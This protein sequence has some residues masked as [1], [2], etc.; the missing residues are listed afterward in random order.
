M[1]AWRQ[2]LRLV[3]R[4]LHYLGLLACFLGTLIPGYSPAQSARPDELTTLEVE[5][6]YKV[7]VE[8]NLVLVRVVVRDA[9]GQTVGNLRREDFR[10]FDNGKPQ[11][12]SSF[13]VVVPSSEGGLA[14]QAG[15]AQA[16]PEPAG[17]KDL[18][19]S[20]P[21]RYLGLYFDDVHMSFEDVVHVQKAAG[22]YL[23]EAIT[24][25]DRLGIF[26]ASG[27]GNLDFTDD[28]A[29]LRAA[30]LRLRSR[31][32]IA[33]GLR[34]CPEIFEYQAYLIIHERNPFA[35]E[36]AVQEAIHCQYGDDQ[37]HLN[38]AQSITESAALRR[39]GEFQ[40]NTESSLRGLEGV[41][42]RMSVLPGQRNIVVVSPGFLTVTEE[43]RLSGIVD[44]ALRERTIISTLDSKGLFAPVPFGDASKQPVVVPRRPDLM[45]RKLEFELEGFRKTADV[46]DELARG[47]GGLYF[48]DS[49]NYDEGFRRVAAPPESYYT[50]AFSPQNLKFEGRFH[51]LKVKLVNYPA[52]SIEA[53]RGYFAPVQSQ[54]AEAR[55]KERITQ[56][57]FSQDELSE[58]PL[59]VHTQ[60]FK[61]TQLDAS[62]SV[63][64]R[65]DLRFVRFRKAEGRNLNNLTVVTALFDR[66]GNYLEGREKRVEF[67][68]L[69]ASLER[70]VGTG[71]T[72]RTSFQVKPGTYLVREVVRDTE[73]DR[74]TGLTR[75][76]EIPY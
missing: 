68:L 54:N 14:A 7:E 32:A 30:L 69:D 62:L 19:P 33:E 18:L 12:V 65:V 67:K 31:P 40:S 38:E 55:A 49:N 64:A 43:I 45:G 29:K 15:Q 63:L 26:T 21:R 9:K 48:H 73:G 39:L 60:F 59:E 50:L 66:D 41:V 3:G 47:T 46:L 36:A 2:Q 72:M 35:T 24:P 8:R 56:A 27:Q 74:L 25:G 20:T 5:P 13:S 16:P 6:T 37:S 4:G 75:T 34:P 70:L 10:L 23:A 42:R 1:S 71:L 17:E 61:R 22:N 11:T 57:L 76:V 44:R 52:L 28:R 53:R 51:S 58:I